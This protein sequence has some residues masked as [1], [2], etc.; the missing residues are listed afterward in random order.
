MTKYVIAPEQSLPDPS[1]RSWYIWWCL[2]F[3]IV[4][5]QC[6]SSCRGYADVE[7]KVPCRN[8]EKTLEI[9]RSCYAEFMEHIFK[10]LECY[11]LDETKVAF[12]SRR[13]VRVALYTY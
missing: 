7:G 11:W 4:R 9:Y 3:M 5:L 2:A 6:P 8:Q 10:R 12:V 13:D 1:S